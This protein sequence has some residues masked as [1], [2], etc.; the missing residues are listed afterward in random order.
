MAMAVT[1][2]YRLKAEGRFRKRE[3]LVDRDP[4]T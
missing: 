1:Q 4:D 2:V 3:I